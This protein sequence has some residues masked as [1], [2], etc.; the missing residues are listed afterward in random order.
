MKNNTSRLSAVCP[1]NAK[2]A[3]YCGKSSNIIYPINRLS[4]EKAMAP[5]SSILPGKS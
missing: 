5:H 1:R 4:P 3:L 2:L